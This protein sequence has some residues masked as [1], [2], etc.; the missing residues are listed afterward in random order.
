MNTIESY[1]TLKF[2]PPTATADYAKKIPEKVQKEIVAYANLLEKYTVEDA[3]VFMIA[4]YC[5]HPVPI[6]NEFWKV[7]KEALVRYYSV[8]DIVEETVTEN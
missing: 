3:F 1:I 7:L 4:V 6:E 8:E 2:F 5:N